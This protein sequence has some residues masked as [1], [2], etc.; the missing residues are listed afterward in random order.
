PHELLDSVVKER[1]VK[2]FRLNRGAHSTDTNYPVKQLFRN[3][4][5]FLFRLQMLSQPPSSLVS[6]RRMLYR[7]KSRP[8]SHTLLYIYVYLGAIAAPPCSRPFATAAH[9]QPNARPQTLHVQPLDKN[10]KPAFEKHCR[11]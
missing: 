9:W 11:P 4:S 1:L 8:K 2:I 5:N 7:K 3:F 6:R 10:I